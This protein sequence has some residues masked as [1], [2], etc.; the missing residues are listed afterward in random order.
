MFRFGFQPSRY[1][2]GALNRSATHPYLST[3]LPHHAGDAGLT[4]DVA[5]KHASGALDHADFT[6]GPCIVH[7]LG[8]AVSPQA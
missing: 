1:K 7:V 6:P 2:T 8:L 5:F 4:R 3:V